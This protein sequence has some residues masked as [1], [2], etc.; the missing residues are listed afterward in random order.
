M[1]LMAQCSVLDPQ[2]LLEGLKIKKLTVIRNCHAIL[3]SV[4]RAHCIICHRETP[5]I[6]QPLSDIKVLEQGENISFY[7]GNTEKVL[8]RLRC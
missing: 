4:K 2:H 8:K 5:S 3:K 7:D 6:D 1:C